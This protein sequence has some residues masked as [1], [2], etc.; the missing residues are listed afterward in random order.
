MSDW[1]DVAH[2]DQFKSGERRI[3]S[4]DDVQI[5][6][7][8]DRYLLA[9]LEDPVMAGGAYRAELFHRIELTRLRHRLHEAIM[10]AAERHWT[11][12]HV[13]EKLHH[14]LKGAVAQ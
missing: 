8:P 10:D 14:A 5:Q 3:V 11:V 7:H 1:I 4:V 13:T 6:L 12:Q 9:A 2:A